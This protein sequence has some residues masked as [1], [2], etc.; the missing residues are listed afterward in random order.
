MSNSEKNQSPLE[1]AA[2][3]MRQELERFER[4]TEQL[5]RGPAN[6]QKT[7]DRG[8]EM[9]NEAADSHERFSGHLKSL[10]DAVA[11]ARDRQAASAET[12]RVRTKELVE[13]RDTFVDVQKRFL[14]LGE[15][16][17]GLNAM[18]LELAS[19]SIEGDQDAKAL[20]E[21]LDEA[22]EKMSSVHD[23]AKELMAVSKTEG[24]QDLEREADSLAQ[25]VGSARNK[26]ELLR[27][28]VQAKR[29]QTN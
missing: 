27:E 17:K 10:I 9:V 25:R 1:A 23:R 28:A 6:S 8:I 11:N 13:R 7:I 20:V 12:L 21:K 19:V 29:T 16:A 24:L 22:L 26:M 5:A 2:S 14:V 15:E 4:I 18:V 3:K